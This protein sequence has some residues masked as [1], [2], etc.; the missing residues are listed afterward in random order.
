MSEAATNLIGAP[1]ARERALLAAARS[2]FVEQGFDASAIS[3]IARRA[4]VATGTVYLYFHNK[5]T[6]LLHV[7][8]DF[9]TTLTSDIEAHL[10]E[11]DDHA[12]R[13]RYVIARHLQALIA[14][15]E[16]S[17]LF[18]REV[19]APD[20]RDGGLIRNVKQRYASVL[21]RVLE[22]GM[23]GGALRTDIPSALAQAIV[24]GGL[25]Q[26]T[27]RTWTGRPVTDGVVDSLTRLL[28]KPEHAAAGD[29]SLIAVLQKIDR[30]SEKLGVTE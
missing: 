22:E 8:A 9:V 12:A 27:L 19:H 21:S 23:V 24:F 2:V 28:T 30:L 18:V 17:A 13:L 25:E 26:L 5:R 6:L 16:L 14:E 7:L 15:P 20:E 1:G 4:G 10:R 3:E 11:L 29:A